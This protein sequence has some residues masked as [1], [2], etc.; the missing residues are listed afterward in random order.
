MPLIR[1]H[2]D[3]IKLYDDLDSNEKRTL[4][5]QL[6]EA[7]GLLN[8]V[9]W[10]NFEEQYVKEYY[11]RLVGINR[12]EVVSFQSMPAYVYSKD[13]DGNINANPTLVKV[14]VS[15][16]AFDNPIIGNGKIVIGGCFYFNVRIPDPDLNYSPN[17]EMDDIQSGS[18]PSGNI[19]E[20]RFI[21]NSDRDVYVAKFGPQIESI[22]KDK[23]ELGGNVFSSI[24]LNLPDTETDYNTLVTLAL[25]LFSKTDQRFVKE[26]LFKNRTN[27][28]ELTPFEI[29]R[30][31]FINEIEYSTTDISSL[32]NILNLKSSSLK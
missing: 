15:G 7:P 6:G 17:I 27:K 29:E 23:P 14:A 2:E 9:S 24:L 5:Q 28:G 22:P 11:D 21:I 18:S 8:K 4:L 13:N 31:L 12:R 19:F 30:F 20:T 25:S 16:S 3:H 1:L 32:V 26:Y 10:Y